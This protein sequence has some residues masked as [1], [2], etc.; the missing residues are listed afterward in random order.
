VVKFEI[1]NESK[2]KGKSAFVVKRVAYVVIK[3]GEY[4]ELLPNSR[5]QA[6]H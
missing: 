1:V 2:V 3:D 6:A 4:M 5:S